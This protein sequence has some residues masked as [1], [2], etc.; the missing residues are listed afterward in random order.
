LLQVL[1]T[2]AKVEAEEAQRE[3]NSCFEPNIL[4][5]LLQLGPDEAMQQL[6]ACQTS[7]TSTSRPCMLNMKEQGSQHT[8]MC[9]RIKNH[10]ELHSMYCMYT[11]SLNCSCHNRL[12]LTL[13]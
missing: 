8:H 3:E 7:A 5:K 2:K 12:L 6:D 10:M 4:Y 1:M 9:V 11:P 13:L